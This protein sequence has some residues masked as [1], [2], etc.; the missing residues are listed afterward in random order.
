M[1]AER[2]IEIKVAIVGERIIPATELQYVKDNHCGHYYKYGDGYNDKV[3][4]LT[5]MV[6]DLKKKEFRKPIV[7]EVRQKTE[8]FKIGE[9]VY[10]DAGNYPKVI[11]RRTIVDI[12]YEHYISSFVKYKK[13]DTY[14]IDKI[15]EETRQ[16]LLPTDLIEFRNYAPTFV[17]NDGYKTHYTHQLLRFED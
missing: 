8:D 5:D 6:W 14:D 15:P 11:K 13:L 16:T 12:V 17:L 4:T 2:Y 9:V 3:T 10:V 1:S 7:I